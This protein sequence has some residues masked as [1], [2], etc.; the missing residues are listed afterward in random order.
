[1]YNLFNIH[2]NN[3]KHNIFY[4]FTQLLYILTFTNIHIYI[5]F[6]FNEVKKG[7]E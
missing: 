5:Y 3:P 2:L 7:K 1:M 4:S 6:G